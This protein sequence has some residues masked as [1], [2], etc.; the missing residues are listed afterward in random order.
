MTQVPFTDNIIL[1]ASRRDTFYRN[2]YG[3]CPD[4]LDCVNIYISYS[5]SVHCTPCKIVNLWKNE[6]MWRGFHIFLPVSMSRHYCYP[7][8]PISLHYRKRSYH[9]LYFLYWIRELS[10][11]LWKEGVSV[12]DWWLPIFPA[13]ALSMDQIQN[14]GLPLDHA[15]KKCAPLFY[16]APHSLCT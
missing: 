8:K 12:H 6:R 4:L 13:P 10:C 14:F 5:T 11:F 3:S 1:T 9:S 16:I 2:L 7:C 15:P